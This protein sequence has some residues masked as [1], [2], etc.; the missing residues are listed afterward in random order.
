MIKIVD[1]ININDLQNQFANELN[2]ILDYW[3]NYSVDKDFGGFFGSV[4]NDNAVNHTANK[5]AVLNA[6][7]LWSFSAGYKTTGNRYYKKMAERS[8]DYIINNFIDKELGGVY[9]SLQHDGKMADAKKQIYAIAFTIYGLAEYYQISDN[10]AALELAKQ[11]FQ[12]IE[13][14]SYDIKKGGYIEAFARDWSEIFDARL[15]A[16]DANERK[17]MNTHLHI[18]EAYTNLYRVWKDEYLALKIKELIFV[19]KNHIIN[20]TNHH[21]HLFFDDDW[22]VKSNTISYGH[23]IE[24]SWLLLEAAEVLGEKDIIELIKEAAVVIA[25]C[26]MEGLGEDGSLNYEFEPHENLMV[27]EKHW[28]VQA[29]AMVGFLNAWQLTND[30]RFFF[31]FLNAWKFIQSSIIDKKNGEWFWGVDKN[32]ALMQGYDKAG[33]WKCPYHNSRACIEVRKRLRGY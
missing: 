13:K 7:I 8:Y 19:F 25:K 21:L 11:L 4:S 22:N 9:W 27:T 31:L 28:W 12:D 15:S 16:K 29:E 32:G 26:S 17:T 5:G 24:A 2:N 33:F 10:A 1:D 14:Y 23:D 30:K 20:P 3:M 18:L 6:R